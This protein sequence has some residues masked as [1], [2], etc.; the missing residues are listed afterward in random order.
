MDARRSGSSS[1]SEPRALSRA[2]AVVRS[3]IADCRAA[4]SSKLPTLEQ[5]AHSAGVSYAT[6]LKALALPGIRR[7]VRRRRGSGIHV[8][9][10]VQ[11]DTSGVGG[12]GT[13]WRQVGLELERDM[14]FGTVQKRGMLPLVKELAARY[15]VSR[16]TMSRA[17]S[18]LVRRGALQRYKRGFR[19]VRDSASALAGKGAVVILTRGSPDQQLADP[20][21][22]HRADLRALERECMR[23]GVRTEWV[24]YHYSDG[25]LVVANRD[26]LAYSR[27]QLD[28]ILGFVLFTRSLDTLTVHDACARLV[29]QRKP[30]AVFDDAGMSYGPDPLPLHPLMRVFT[31]ANSPEPGRAVGRALLALGHREVAYVGLNLDADWSRRRLQG[32]REAFEQ[33]GMRDGVVKVAPRTR[34]AAAL[35]LSSGQALRL[36]Q[37]A[38]ALR[39][40]GGDRTA[41]LVHRALVSADAR[42]VQRR[43]A[44]LA[45]HQE[46][47]EC[48]APLLTREHGGE[49]VTAWVGEND[50]CALACRKVAREA[51]IRVSA[52]L[53]IVGFDDLLDAFLNGLSSY[54]FNS[55]GAMHAC[56]WHVLNQRRP[57]RAKPPLDVTGFLS[58]R[59]S[60]GR[61]RV[62]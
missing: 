50:D 49:G 36:L 41:G 55:A 29:R 21:G 25:G 38:A 26:G 48:L 24:F 22:R 45:R 33:A 5:M 34:E 20:S 54:N 42:S 30:V 60:L 16:P 7:L 62:R 15:G 51:G 57:G 1:G 59:S 56:L 58:V 10:M 17:L 39:V 11:H 12:K 43:I 40:D 3:C 14:L 9:D 47:F 61:A 23:L 19:V 35:A 32:L 4:G 46:R 44:E 8:A 2:E 13:R 52:D 27:E 6:I 28:H 53:S 31:S 18:E 37:D